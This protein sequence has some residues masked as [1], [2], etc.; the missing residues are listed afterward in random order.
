VQEAV[1]D[2]RRLRELEHKVDHLTAKKR[3]ATERVRKLEAERE[4]LLKHVKNTTLTVQNVSDAVDIE[5]NVW[6][7]AKMFDVDLKNAGHLSKSK[8]INFI[9]DQGRKMDVSLKAIKAL[10]V[11]CTELF[12]ATV[13]SSKEA[14]TSLSYSDLTPRDMMEIQG[15]VVEGGS[16]HLEEVEQVKNITTITVIVGPP[17]FAT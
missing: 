10:I 2:L 11:S 8:M 14:E 9:M 1:Q 15:V 7:K 3:K 17:V 13:E 12:P 4:K 6:W 5:R 16:Q